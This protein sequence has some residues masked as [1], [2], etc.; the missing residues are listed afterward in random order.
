[1]KKLYLEVTT[2][3]ILNVNDDAII[4]DI[5]DQMDYDFTDNTGTCDIVDTELLEY[6]VY[7]SK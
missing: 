4:D 7:D 5:I 1:M 6:V 2:R 3:L